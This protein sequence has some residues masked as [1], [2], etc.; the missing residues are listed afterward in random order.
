V[1]SECFSDRPAPFGRHRKKDKFTCQ[2]CGTEKDA[3]LYGSKDINRH[4][5]E[6]TEC[7]LVC[8]D[9]STSRAR[10]LNNN[11]SACTRCAKL[12][13]RG[14]FS[15]V[16]QKCRDYKKWKCDACQRPTCTSCGVQEPTPLNRSITTGTHICYRCTYPPCAKGCGTFR[17]DTA[18][19]YR[20][21]NMLLWMCANCKLMVK[22]SAAIA[23]PSGADRRT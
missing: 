12:L 23:H 6:G 7:E 2:Q 20:V 21:D 13:P 9:C 19:R 11:S 22:R 4:A 17:P 1:C 15:V 16:M 18:K 8:L 10:H 14:A 5:R 3:R